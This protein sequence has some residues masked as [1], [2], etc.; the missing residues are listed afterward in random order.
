M[1]IHCSK[2]AVMACLLALFSSGSF[3]ATCPDPS[4]FPFSGCN[5]GD[6]RPSGFPYFEQLVDVR[7]KEKKNG[8]NLNASFHKGSFLSYLNVSLSDIL[9]ISKTKFKLKVKVRDGVASGRVKIRGAIDELGMNRAQT[10][11]TADLSGEWGANLTGELIGFNTMNIVCND[12]INAYLGG[13]CTENESIYLSLLESITTGERKINTAGVAVTTIP[14]PAA[15]WLF[16]S[17][18]LGL[19]GIAGFKRAA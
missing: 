7:Y 10:L 12:I 13:G 3:A 15:V 5:V 1:N 11:M 9:D 14:L 18:L 16:G 4:E 2:G 6:V 17:G 8:F 19:A